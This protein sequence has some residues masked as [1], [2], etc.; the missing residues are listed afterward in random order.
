MHVSYCLPV[1][2][3]H[4]QIK[5]HA[6]HT[7]LNYSSERVVACVCV[8]VCVCGFHSTALI[9]AVNE[10]NAEENERRD[11]QLT[12]VTTRLGDALERIIKLEARVAELERNAQHDRATQAAATQELR[13]YSAVEL[14]KRIGTVMAQIEVATTK[15]SV[16]TGHMQPRDRP[17]AA[18]MPKYGSTVGLGRSSTSAAAW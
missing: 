5:R 14:E 16:I 7:F 9:D 11:S 13:E 17:A 10:H 15:L 18:D 1:R 3:R 4:R 12:S 2:D 6:K 8:C